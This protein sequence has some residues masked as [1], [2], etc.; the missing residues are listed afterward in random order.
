LGRPNIT[1]RAHRRTNVRFHRLKTEGRALPADAESPD[2]VS[3][4]KVAKEIGISQ[5][6]IRKYPCS[7]LILSQIDELGL[8]VR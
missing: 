3:M 2:V 4:T 7:M 5:S 1:L 8:E 6:T